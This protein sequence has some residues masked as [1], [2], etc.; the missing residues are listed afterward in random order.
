M[1][2]AFFNARKIFSP[3]GALLLRSFL[4]TLATSARDTGESCS[5]FQQQQGVFGVFPVFYFHEMLSFFL[6]KIVLKNSINQFFFD[7]TN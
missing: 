3:P 2:K 1:S 7:F 6:W 4:T 5:M